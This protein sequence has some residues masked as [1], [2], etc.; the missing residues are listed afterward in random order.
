VNIKNSK[1]NFKGRKQMKKLFFL[2]LSVMLILY[3]P[4][5]ASSATV[6]QPIQILTPVTSTSGSPTTSQSN[7]P[8]GQEVSFSKDILPIFQQYSDAHHGSDSVLPLVNYDG[9][10]LDVVP[11]QP[12]QSKLYLR[13]IGQGGP[14]MPPGNPL[15]EKLITLIYNWIKQGAKNN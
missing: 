12:E 8:S 3:F 4:A 14:M 11:G 7:S 10:M 9:V 2:L 15:P 6:T 5:C 1:T 13:L